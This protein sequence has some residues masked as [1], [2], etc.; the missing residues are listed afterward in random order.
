MLSRRAWAWLAG[1]ILVVEAAILPWTAHLFDA[2]VFISHADGFLFMHVQPFHWWWFGAVSLIVLLLSQVPVLIFPRFASAVPA[3]I[4]LLKAPAWFADLGT[5]AIVRF[6]SADARTANWWALRYFLDPSVVFVTV[7]HGQADAIPNLLVVGGLVLTILG[8]YEL[9]AVAFGIGTGTKFYPAAFV[10]LLLAVTLRR[11]GFVRTLSALGVFVL[12]AAACLVPVF[13]GRVGPI[14]SFFAFNSFGPSGANVSP[15]SL[16]HLLPLGVLA[17]RWEQLGAVVVPIALALVELRHRAEARD[18]A[19]AAMFTA[20][21]IVF[22]NPGAHE[23]FY[24][25]IAGPL[26]LYCAVSNNGLVSLLG[27]GVSVCGIL[28]QFCQEGS[29]EYFIMTFGKGPSSVLFGCYAHERVLEAVILGC[30]LLIVFASVRWRRPW[31]TFSAWRWLSYAASLV[32]FALFSTT[33]FIEMA[34]AK[35]VGAGPAHYRNYEKALSTIALAPAVRRTK[36]G[37]TLTYDAPDY[38]TFAGNAF[39]AQFVHAHLGYRLF[40]PEVMTIRGTRIFLHGRPAIYESVDVQLLNQKGVRIT[41]EF[42]VTKLLRPYRVFEQF[43]EQPCSLIRDNPLL[44]YRFDLHAARR[45]AAQRNLLERLNVF[46]T[47]LR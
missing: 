9:A 44:I 43:E 37:C 39:A 42:D 26:V 17:P 36:N 5:A 1:I 14:V 30:V 47:T 4:V 11:A 15:P 40:S 27:L 19:R 28:I 3:R 2:T 6:A 38:V 32:I 31:M 33:V 18:V 24:L 22:L 12:I 34:S 20:M 23:P 13:Y 29:N 16:W 41:Q 8:R 35:H 7:L 46:A 25:W 45:F 10:P 21:A